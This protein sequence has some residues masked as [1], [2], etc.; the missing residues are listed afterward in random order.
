M[1][2]RECP[3]CGAEKPARVHLCQACWREVPWPLKVDIWGAASKHRDDPT[4]AKFALSAAISHL[5]QH[6]TAL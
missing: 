6:S 3:H 4:P 2:S 5:K 1:T